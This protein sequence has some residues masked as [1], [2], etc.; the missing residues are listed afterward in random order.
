MSR[1]YRRKNDLWDLRAYDWDYSAGYL[2][3][4]YIERNS[5]KY[6]KAKADFHRDHHRYGSGVPSWFVNLYCEKPF[7]QKSKQQIINWT[8]NPVENDCILPKFRKD[9]G[10]MY[11]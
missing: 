11:W 2:R 10:W 8:K 5:K 3:K 6:F 1:T 4:Y 9:A 7:R